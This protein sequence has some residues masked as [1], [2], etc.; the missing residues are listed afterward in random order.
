MGMITYTFQDFEKHID[1]PHFAIDLISYHK[2]TDLYRIACDANMYDRQKNITVNEYVKKIYSIAGSP[3]VDFT[4]SNNKIASNFF[5]HLNV[6]RCTYSLGN[7][8]SFLNEGTK[9]KLGKDFDQILSS[10][11]Y[12]SLIHGVTYIFWNVDQCYNF[13]ITEFVP[14]VDEETGELRAG[15]R[16]WQLDDDR[17]LM[18]TI[19]EE[20]GFTKYKYYDNQL[21]EIQPKTAYKVRIKVV[22]N[23]IIEESQE[24]YNALP[25]IPLY[26]SELH[27]STLV[28][29]RQAIDSFDL[30]RSGFA[31][32]LSDCAE[33]Y[34]LIS[35]CDGM[36]DKDLQRFRD[37]LLLNHIALGGD[38]NATVE[39]HT[40]EIPYTARITY[41]ENIRQGLY[42]DFGAFDVKSFATGQKT[43]T[44]IN[45]SYQPLD[46]NADD[47]EFQIKKSISALLALQGIDDTPIFKRNIIA[48]ETEQVEMVAKESE[49]LDTET[50]LKKLPNISIDEIPDIMKRKAF[51][52]SS[53]FDYQDEEDEEDDDV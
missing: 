50:I 28:G 53:K 9:E 49:W 45:A 33:I 15:I 14:L 37:R 31:N 4:A 3:I 32:D 2:G 52:D 36:T 6:Q 1:K 5:R 11:G 44:E 40:Q 41:L 27:Q 42:E 22:N 26:G 12:K 13:D 29:M 20:D 10:A 38:E 43:A 18:F 23:E 19:Y 48:N 39:A 30:I 46:E 47:F 34:W 8:V 51:E 25:I 24:N 16:F 7:G 35:G 17:P 21:L